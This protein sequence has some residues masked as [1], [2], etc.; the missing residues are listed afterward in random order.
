[1]LYSQESGSIRSPINAEA[2]PLVI[3]IAKGFL[4]KFA[5]SGGVRKCARMLHRNQPGSDVKSH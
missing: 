4:Q 2:F 3:I 1:M 5:T